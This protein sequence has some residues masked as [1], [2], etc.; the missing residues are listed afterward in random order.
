MDID[1]QGNRMARS[2]IKPADIISFL[3]KD[4]DNIMDG[5]KFKEKIRNEQEKACPRQFECNRLLENFPNEQRR[6]LILLQFRH[7]KDFR[8]PT[9]NVWWTTSELFSMCVVYTVEFQVCL[10]AAKLNRIYSIS[11]WCQ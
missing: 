10:G 7:S 1:F 6:R 2:G 4:H 9:G 3:H 8:Q 5:D 11:S